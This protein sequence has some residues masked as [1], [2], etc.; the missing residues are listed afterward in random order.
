MS[1]APTTA[2]SPD[3]PGFVGWKRDCEA[4]IKKIYGTESSEFADFRSLRFEWRGIA[5]AM[6]GPGAPKLFQ[7][8]I[9][10]AVALLD[11]FQREQ[12]EEEH[13]AAL[14]QSIDLQKGTKPADAKKIFVVHG[15]DEALKEKVARLISQLELD[16]VILHEAADQAQTIIEK[17]EKHSKVGFAVVLLTGDD[18]GRKFAGG[19]LI[20]RARQNV[21]FEC[22]YFVGLLG[23]DRVLALKE[24][25]VESFSDYDGVLVTKVDIAGAWRMKL[26][27]ELKA[28]GYDVDMNRL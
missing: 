12:T 21:V 4:I 24:D 19:D 1:R 27:R 23:R 28:A 9:A 8:S 10:R 18:E 2:L 22:G 11:S 3:D 5:T 14:Q 6:H 17:L 15:H 20:R 25:G 26:A 13:T 7:K 16:P